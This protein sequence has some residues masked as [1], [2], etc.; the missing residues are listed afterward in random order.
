M[1]MW[2]GLYNG[3]MVCGFCGLCSALHCNRNNEW[4]LLLSVVSSF[5]EG[6][7]AMFM[8]DGEKREIAGGSRLAISV[9]ES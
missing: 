8:C 6:L 7:R 9:F 1:R 5:N 2:F 3:T 4:G